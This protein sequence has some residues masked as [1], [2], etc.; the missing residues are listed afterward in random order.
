YYVSP[1][2]YFTP[3]LQ[4]QIYPHVYRAPTAG[5]R[6]GAIDFGIRGTLAG[7]W[8][9][10]GM[11]ADSSPGPYGWTRSIAFACDYYDP[12]QVRI[13]IGGTI[14]PAGVWAIDPAAPRPETITP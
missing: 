3:E 6:D 1:W 9:L 10:T 8:F 7:D 4:A 2:K 11:P 5:D 12:S 13:S 14:G